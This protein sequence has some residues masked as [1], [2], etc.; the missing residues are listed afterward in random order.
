MDVEIRTYELRQDG[1]LEP[2]SILPIS[3]YGGVC[4]NVGDT[5]CCDHF[6]EGS[7]FYSV[8][9]RHFIAVGA[10]HGWAII[11]R[12]I[13]AAQQHLTVYDAWNADTA[14]WNEV[15]EREREEELQAMQKSVK[16]PKTAPPKNAKRSSKPKRPLRK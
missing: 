1:R 11:T 6:A 7:R 10:T 13:E 15:D 9:R 14:F 2:L 8:Q 5:L 12:R 4:P 3:Y 16:S